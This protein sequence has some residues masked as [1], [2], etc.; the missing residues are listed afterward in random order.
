MAE[1]EFQVINQESHSP[2]GSYADSTKLETFA[3]PEL[4]TSKEYTFNDEEE[5]LELTEAKESF[6]YEF[7]KYQSTPHDLKKTGFNYTNLKL[8]CKFPKC[9]SFKGTKISLFRDQYVYL[10]PGLQFITPC[11][12]ILFI[13]MGY[14]YFVSVTE[15][16]A[17]NWSKTILTLCTT[18]F[19][20]NM[21]KVSF[22]NP[23]HILRTLNLKDLIKDPKNP[24]FGHPY[25]IERQEELVAAFYRKHAHN[26]QC[27]QCLVFKDEAK[28]RSIEHCDECEMCVEGYDHHC[29]V[30]GNCVGKR[31]LFSFNSMIWWF[32][33]TVCF[34]YFCMFLA[35][36]SCGSTA[37]D[38][39]LGSGSSSSSNDE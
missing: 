26:L 3:S 7:I 13:I 2:V 9:M 6:I 4:T 27:E 22:T 1:M 34:A 18:L 11:I 38:G 21:V 5:D 33:G 25:A 32:M 8:I 16:P 31:N 17:I 19:V 24:F 39:S 29:G 10:G 30:L 12:L 23:G 14:R 35:L 28:D 36:Y 20:L 15:C 37:F